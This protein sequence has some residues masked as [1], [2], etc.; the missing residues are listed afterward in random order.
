MWNPVHGSLLCFLLLG[1]LCFASLRVIQHK[2][3]RSDT[4]L[5]AHK[6]TPRANAKTL[7]PTEQQQQ[8]Q[9]QHK[10]SACV[11]RLSSA[12]RRSA[13]SEGFPLHHVCVNLQVQAYEMYSTKQTRQIC[14]S[15]LI[16][17]N[18]AGRLSKRTGHF[19]HLM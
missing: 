3:T 7:G 5:H 17:S 10:E 6:H 1:F 18:K 16:R 11:K 14:S 2:L 15:P 19:K 4:N 13:S 9:Q 12:G 8:Q